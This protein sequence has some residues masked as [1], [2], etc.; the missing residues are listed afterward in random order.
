MSLPTDSVPNER[1]EAKTATPPKPPLVFKESKSHG[2][3]SKMHQGLKTKKNKVNALAKVGSTK[4][5]C[6]DWD[7]CRYFVWD[8]K[9]QAVSFF[10]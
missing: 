4:Y 3:L 1:E 8:S 10:K 6:L 9:K 5:L 7:K 2:F